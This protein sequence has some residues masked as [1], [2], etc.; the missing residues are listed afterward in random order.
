[1]MT[2][3]VRENEA[4]TSKS[5]THQAKLDAVDFGTEQPRYANFSM[6][7]ATSV[8]VVLRKHSHGDNFL[9][10][11][12]NKNRF[13]DKL[14]ARSVPADGAVAEM[15]LRRRAICFSEHKVDELSS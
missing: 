15:I 6:K 8:L 2:L 3:A 14:C 11:P 10:E 12:L 9:S 7:S 5:L 1:M 4:G 13:N